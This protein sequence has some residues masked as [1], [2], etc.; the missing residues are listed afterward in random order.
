[1]FKLIK[2]SMQKL[3]TTIGRSRSRGGAGF[4]LI[5]LLVVIAIIAILAA[6]LLPAL[7]AAKKKAQQANCMSNL[8]Q[9]GLGMTIY[10]DDYNDIAPGCASVNQVGFS[11]EDWIYWLPTAAAPNGSGQASATLINSPISRG[12]PGVSSNLF[13]CPGDTYDAE[14]N[15]VNSGLG[16][17]NGAYG[18]SYSFNSYIAADGKTTMGM[19]SVHTVNATPHFWSPYRL[20]LVKSPSNKIMFAECQTSAK[21]SMKSSGECS[22]S[23]TDNGGN[24]GAKPINDGRFSAGTGNKVLTSRHG[25]KGDVTFGDGHVDAVTWQFGN[26]ATN[27]QPDL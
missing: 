18:F 11:L 15:T 5:E 19:A 6:M 21:D 22:V 26:N 1:M 12:I 7:A 13:R 3:Q 23:S 20:S 10:V 24:S 25:K 16:T 2:P 9:L 17:F 4:T 14:R 27:S 8:K